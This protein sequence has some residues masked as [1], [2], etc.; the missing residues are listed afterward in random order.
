[1]LILWNELPADF[2]RNSSWSYSIATSLWVNPPNISSSWSARRGVDESEICAKVNAC[3]FSLHRTISSYCLSH[4]ERPQKNKIHALLAH[5]CFALAKEEIWGNENKHTP[6]RIYFMYKVKF[7]RN[8]KKHSEKRMCFL[9]SMWLQFEKCAALKN[10]VSTCALSQNL[11]W[12]LSRTELI[13]IITRKCNQRY[14]KLIYA[15]PVMFL[16]LF[17]SSSFFRLY[18]SFISLLFFTL[19]C[20]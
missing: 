15:A 18:K 1:M 9:A 13:I 5:T 2:S 20:L 11:F 12:M 4:F 3:S 10:L 14:T 6:I 17:N 19:F 7:K 8:S 16:Q